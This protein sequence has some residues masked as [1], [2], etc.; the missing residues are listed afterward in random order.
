MDLAISGGED[1]LL[2]SLS[3]DLPPTASYAQQRRLVSYLPSG[4][5]NLN[6]NG[7]RW[8]GEIPMETGLTLQPSESVQSSLIPE[9]LFCSSLMDAL[10]N[11]QD[12]IVYWWRLCGGRRHVRTGAPYFQKDDNEL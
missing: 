3:F 4:A 7:L 12:K 8:H 2:E 11:F 6:L 10:S 5:S 1:S 9:P